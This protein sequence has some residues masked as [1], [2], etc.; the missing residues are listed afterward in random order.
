MSS[1]LEALRKLETEKA[2]ADRPP[3]EGFDP[4]T[5]KRDLV[6]GGAWR[7]WLPLRLGP[8]AAVLGGGLLLIALAAVSVGV[9]IVLLKPGAGPVQVANAARR[10]EAPSPLQVISPPP[11]PRE[12]VEAPAPEPAKPE[13]TPSPPLSKPV[14]KPPVPIAPEPPAETF[15]IAAGDT[16]GSMP[17]I[18]SHPPPAPVP[19]PRARKQEGPVDIFALPM[20]S[21]TEKVRYGL[22]NLQVNLACPANKYRPHASAIINL[23]QVMA[24]QRIPDSQAILIGVHMRAIAV[25]IVDTGKQYQIR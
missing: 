6:G 22:S 11:A 19:E 7:N 12:P 25:E 21:E 13:P 24:G 10:I 17:E 8:L 16:A 23:K 14:A 20:L 15:Q 1:I 9:S 18:E 5:A 4:K 3:E 2:E